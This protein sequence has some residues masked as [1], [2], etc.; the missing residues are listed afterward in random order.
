MSIFRCSSFFCR[1]LFYLRY[2]SPPY[3]ASRPPRVS[4]TSSAVWLLLLLFSRNQTF[5]CFLDCTHQIRFKSRSE[6]IV[7]LE[8]SWTVGGPKWN[9]ASY[10]CG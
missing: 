4:S 9:H 2:F 5:Y 7:G 10:M 3:L 6:A 1:H 8:I